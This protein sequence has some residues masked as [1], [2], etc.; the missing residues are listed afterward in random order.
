MIMKQQSLLGRFRREQKLSTMRDPLAEIGERVNFEAFR[1]TLERRSRRE[2][3]GL[4]GRPAYDIV[5][6]FKILVV[7]VLYDLSDGALE[8]RIY[9]SYFAAA[10][11]RSYRPGARSGCK[12]DLG[13]SKAADEE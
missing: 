6:M 2:S 8:M 12:N 7:G 10:G 1:T 11:L 13:I 9:D 5:L 4:G 3:K